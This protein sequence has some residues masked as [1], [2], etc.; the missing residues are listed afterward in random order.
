M[1]N[2]TSHCII[3]VSITKKAVTRYLNDLKYCSD[4]T[5]ESYLYD[6]LN[7]LSFMQREHGHSRGYILIDTCHLLDWICSIAPTVSSRRLAGIMNI[8]HHFIQ[9]ITDDGLISTNPMTEIKERY[10]KRGWA[11]IA[12]AF[13]S[14][15]PERYLESLRV[16]H[17]FTGHFGSQAQAYIELQRA[18]GKKYR[19]EELAL[20]EFNRF[21]SE[22]SIDSSR[23]VT[24]GIV[25]EWIDGM[26]CTQQCCRGKAFVLRR[27]FHHLV[28]LGSIDNNPVADRII[29]KI[30]I[31]GRSCKPYIFEK[32]QIEEILC[33]AREL[34][35][36][37][38]FLLKPQTMFTVISILYTLG[39]RI[40]EALKLRIKD[41]D[42]DQDTVYIAQT[43]FYKERFV[44]FGPKLGKCIKEYLKLR[45]TVYA[46]VR[47]NDFLFVGQNGKHISD[48]CIREVFKGLLKASGIIDGSEKV[49]PR[50]HDL[51][52]TFAVH[53]LYRWYKEGT[54]VQS[55]LVLLSTFMGHFSIR[56]TQVYLS[57]TDGILEEANK[58]FYGIF[59]SSSIKGDMS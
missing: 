45:Y 20:I 30:G 37:S 57:I 18:A 49:K 39:F 7:F 35:A 28:S 52:H 46:P 42:V 44:P 1:N 25:Q 32:E 8:V 4:R 58:R 47:K 6:I 23:A 29:D 56:S 53:R 55:K 22:L 27:F 13:K 51:R 15:N 17:V 11:G 19:S 33:R 5:K 9:T 38:Q 16:V 10:R 21:I 50:L 2:S 36:N 3:N 43:K 40:S 14:K 31:P 41:I 34:P 48:V 24:P 26:N 54:D 59:R 12:R